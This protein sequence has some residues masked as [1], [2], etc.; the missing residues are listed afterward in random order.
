[1]LREILANCVSVSV[2]DRQVDAKRAIPREE[3][4]PMTTT[5]APQTHQTK[6]VFLGGLSPDTTE[7]EIREVLETIGIVRDNTHTINI[8]SL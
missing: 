8:G 1:M 3:T 5:S 7:D 6:K 2:D 4:P